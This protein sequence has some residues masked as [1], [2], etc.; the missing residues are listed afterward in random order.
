MAITSLITAVAGFV[1]TI[2]HYANH[3]MVLG[4][5]TL[6]LLIV[7]MVTGLMDIRKQNKNGGIDYSK[8]QPGVLGHGIAGIVL[9]LGIIM[10]IIANVR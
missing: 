4:A 2:I 7:S 3:N 10:C 8:V 9:A 6:V 5:V 1:T